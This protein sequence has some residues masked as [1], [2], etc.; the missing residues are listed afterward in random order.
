MRL[1]SFIDEEIEE[2]TAF[3][4]LLF[5]AEGALGLNEISDETIQTLKRLGAK[6]GMKVKKTDS[7][8]DYM[9]RAGKGMESILRY[10]AMVML[11]DVTDNKTRKTL[12]QDM[13]K[14][15]TMQQ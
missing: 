14:V 6:M 9:K 11:T 1:N 5:F 15:L 8:F 13:K 10:A 12:M 3:T 7:I 4:G 2:C